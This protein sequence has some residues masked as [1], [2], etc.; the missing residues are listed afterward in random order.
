VRCTELD[1][2]KEA[3]LKTSREVIRMSMGAKR[4]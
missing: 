4:G 3:G 2:K 1:L